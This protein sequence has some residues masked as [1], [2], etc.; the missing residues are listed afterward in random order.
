MQ[1]RQIGSVAVSAIGLGEMPLSQGG[2]P[3]ED[4]PTRTMHAALDAGVT[5][6][7]TADAYAPEPGRLRPRR[8][9]RWR[10]AL[11]AYGGSTRK[12]WWPPR[13]VISARTARWGLDGSPEYL[14]RPRAVVDDLEVEPIGLYQFHRPDPTVP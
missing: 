12:C 3:S 10:A 8:T 9:A 14:A 1:T 4:R 13:A 11:E 7:D 6:I 5:L 2:P